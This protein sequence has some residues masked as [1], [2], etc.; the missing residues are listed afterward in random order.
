MI[1]EIGR[2]FQTITNGE[3]DILFGTQQLADLIL[4]PQIK[5]PFLAF[6]VGIKRGVIT[7]FW[8]LHFPHDPSAGFLGDPTKEWILGHLPRLRIQR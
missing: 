2:L 4:R 3:G 1:L 7:T 5:L 8:A 6:G